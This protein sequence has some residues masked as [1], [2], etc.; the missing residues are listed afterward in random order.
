MFQNGVD[1]LSQLDDPF[2]VK[3]LKILSGS[4]YPIVFKFCLPVAQTLIKELQMTFQT[5]DVNIWNGNMKYPIETST[6]Q[7]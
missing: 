5:Y 3:K 2:L 4:D 7:T 1:T 6:F